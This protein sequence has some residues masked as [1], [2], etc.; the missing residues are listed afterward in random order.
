[1]WLDSEEAT[2]DSDRNVKLVS[3][4]VQ[5]WAPSFYFERG[6]FISVDLFM[7]EGLGDMR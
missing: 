7:A 6:G 5:L 3:Q 1:M 2:E 4:W